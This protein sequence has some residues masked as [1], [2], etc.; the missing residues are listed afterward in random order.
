MALIQS[1]VN[2]RHNNGIHAD[3][4]PSSASEIRHSLSAH[5]P[6]YIFY[7][8]TLVILNKIKTAYK[9]QINIKN[10]WK[11]FFMNFFWF[12]AKLSIFRQE[13]A[14]AQQQKAAPST[15][16]LNYLIFSSFWCFTKK[17]L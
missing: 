2:L 10:E 17:R 4:H 8:Y 15:Y 6:T 16:K 5:T 7:I 3:W 13:E 12:M 11:I 9:Q 14:K 1:D